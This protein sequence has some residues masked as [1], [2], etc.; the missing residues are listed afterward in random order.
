MTDCRAFKDAM[1][2]KDVSAKIARW[3]LFMEEY[4]Y[5]LEHRAANKM[6]HVDALSRYALV[7]HKEYQMD[8][9]IEEMQRKDGS[10][11]PILKLLEQDREYDGYY[12]QGRVLFKEFEG[13]SLLVV[14]KSMQSELIR[15]LHSEGHFGVRKL[16]DV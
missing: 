8:R 4:D 5:H 12:L 11:Q 7:I 16:M 3:A 14:P 2:K 10:L 13:N 1:A 15:R 9:E 6:K